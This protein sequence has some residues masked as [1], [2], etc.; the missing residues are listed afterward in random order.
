MH[1]LILHQEKMDADPLSK[2]RFNAEQLHFAFQTKNG[3]HYFFF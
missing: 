2:P 3:L 1:I